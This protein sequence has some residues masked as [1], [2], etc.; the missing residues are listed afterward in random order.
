MYLLF[1]ERGREGEREG[2]IHQCV[3]VCHVPST[4]DLA[5]NP[6]MCHDWE[7][8]PLVSRPVLNPLS[9]TSQGYALLFQER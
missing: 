4:E 6:G 3:V 2:E 7:C 1:R 9:H 5:C 8:D